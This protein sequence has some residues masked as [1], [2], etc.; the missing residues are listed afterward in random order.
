MKEL[1]YL[2]QQHFNLALLLAILLHILTIVMYGFFPSDNVRN[3]SVPVL[4]LKLGDMQIASKLQGDTSSFMPTVPDTVDSVMNEQIEKPKMLEN[5]A[6]TRNTKPV[7]STQRT[8][9]KQPKTVDAVKPEFKK[10]QYVR[11]T[12]YDYKA[13][14]PARTP[15]PIKGN[16]LGNTQDE[17]AKAR[18]NYEQL[19]TAWVNQF[20]TLSPE[21]EKKNLKG[22]VVVGLRIDKRGT[23]HYYYIQDSS[24]HQ[25]L[26]VLALAMINKANPVPPVP[27]AYAGEE[28]L[29]FLIPIRFK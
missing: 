17:N 9:S 27:S 10:K 11:E 24:G 2:T 29:E 19:I 18:A 4:N 12:D 20:K 13:L 21:A 7:Q 6:D 15:D 16:T 1:S 28:I 3:I 8:S 22:E 14:N 5:V 26:D 23:I 25:Q